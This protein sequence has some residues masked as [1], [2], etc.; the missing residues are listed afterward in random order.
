MFFHR[1]S[2][3]YDLNQALVEDQHPA[4]QRKRRDSLQAGTDSEQTS[5]AGRLGKGPFVRRSGVVRK[6]GNRQK[7]T[8]AMPPGRTAHIEHID[9][10][11][12]FS[13]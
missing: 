3:S 11:S 6:P 4:T 9:M 5:S 13:P 2:G 1:F 10:R 12:A 8:I 7:Q